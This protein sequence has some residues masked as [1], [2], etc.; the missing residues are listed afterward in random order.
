MART[1][2]REPDD[3]TTITVVVG[4]E[5]VLDLAENPTTGYRWEVE[6][7]GSVLTSSPST[8]ESNANVAIGGG[9]RRQIPL[10]AAQSGET[11]IRVRLRRTWDAPDESI[12]ERTFRV[13]VK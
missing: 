1:F 3:G 12:D 13:R 8:Y 2:L 11:V 7:Q 10:L 5:V 6:S 4:D 9:G